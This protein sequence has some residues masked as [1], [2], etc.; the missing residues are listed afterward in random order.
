MGVKEREPEKNETDK[1]EAL[2]VNFFPSH[3]IL[4]HKT[5]QEVALLAEG[6]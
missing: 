1:P 3:M 2:Q 5:R 6:I 4:F